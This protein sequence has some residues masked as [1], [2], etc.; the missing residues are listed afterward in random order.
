MP[1][2]SRI[3]LWSQPT[4]HTKPPIQLVVPSLL[5]QGGGEEEVWELEPR[6]GSLFLQCRNQDQRSKTNPN[7]SVSLYTVETSPLH[8]SESEGR[9]GGHLGVIWGS[10]GFGIRGKGTHI[11]PRRLVKQCARHAPRVSVP[12]SPSPHRK[13]GHE[14]RGNKVASTMDAIRMGSSNRRHG[15]PGVVSRVFE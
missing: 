6:G 2:F 4:R 14:P 5:D 9:S 1:A 10:W 12:Q 3:T 13:R 15:L 8:V 7:V 11:P